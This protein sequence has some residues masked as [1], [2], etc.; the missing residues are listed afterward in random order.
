LKPKSI[1]EDIE[2]FKPKGVEYI[3]YKSLIEKNKNNFNKMEIKGMTLKS[4]I[5]IV[6][7]AIAKAVLS[8][9]FDE[10]TTTQIVEV[11]QQV[12]NA[13]FGVAVG[14]AIYGIRRRIE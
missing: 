12:L 10:N 8:I 13:L 4:V 11:L 2:K 14:T 9:W 1:H 6:L 3:P 5:I 7:V